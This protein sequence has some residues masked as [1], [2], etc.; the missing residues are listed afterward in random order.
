MLRFIF[1]VGS[2]VV[3]SACATQSSSQTAAPSA[4][5]PAKQPVAKGEEDPNEVICEYERPTGSA[6][7]KKVCFTRQEREDMMRAGQDFSGR[8]RISPS[9]PE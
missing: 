7:I 5:A 8:P 1:A 4:T 3:A 2:L 6:M 9:I